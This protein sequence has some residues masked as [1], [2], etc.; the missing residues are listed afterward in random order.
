[1]HQQ[2]PEALGVF[3]DA[4][5][6]KCRLTMAEVDTVHWVVYRYVLPVLVFA[7]IVLNAVC[8]VVLSRPSLRSTRVVW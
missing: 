7:G 6:A 1:M 3:G 2:H 4:G 5:Q 8:L